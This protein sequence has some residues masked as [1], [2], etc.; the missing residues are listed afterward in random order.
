MH[1]YEQRHLRNQQRAVLVD[2]E[3]EAGAAWFRF[4]IDVA[5]SFTRCMGIGL[6]LLFFDDRPILTSVFDDRPSKAAPFRRTRILLGFVIGMIIARTGPGRNS[7]GRRR[8]GS[9]LGGIAP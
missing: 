8:V 2:V 5:S 6:D 4:D 9:S 1:Q 7:R 3:C